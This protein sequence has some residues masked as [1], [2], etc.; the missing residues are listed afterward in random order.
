VSAVT[1]RRQARQRARERCRAERSL[2]QL[3]IPEP[4]TREQAGLLLRLAHRVRLRDGSLLCT[5]LG[6]LPPARPVRV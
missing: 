2:L 4:L 3:L 1:P 6:R 5:A